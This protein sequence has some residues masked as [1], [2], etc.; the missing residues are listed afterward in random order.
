VSLSSVEDLGTKVYV[1][2]LNFDTTL[3]D[4]QATFEQYGEV[5]DCFIPTDYDGNPRGFAFIQMDEESA[6]AA[7]DG[8]NGTELD[9]RTLNVNKSLPKGTQ[10]NAG[11]KRE[12]YTVR[13]VSVYILYLTQQPD[14]ILLPILLPYFRGQ[15]VRRKSIMGY[16]R[17]SPT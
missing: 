16:R 17:G 9:G 5:K 3:E 2:N 8:L 11:P 15:T 13:N 12:L 10:S 6:L 7:I 14:S 1:G 4:L